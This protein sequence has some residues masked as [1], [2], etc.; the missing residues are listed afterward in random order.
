[1]SEY[2]FDIRILHASLA[3][4]IE[5]IGTLAEQEG[6]DASVVLDEL[7]DYSEIVEKTFIYLRDGGEMV[8]PVEEFLTALQDRVYGI[9]LTLVTDFPEYF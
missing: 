1:M 8:G 6:V 9:E 5:A 4:C 7:K 3:H 2:D